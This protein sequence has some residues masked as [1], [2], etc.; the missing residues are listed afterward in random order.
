LYNTYSLGFDRLAA[1][2]LG[3]NFSPTIVDWP[4][5]ESAAQQIVSENTG[6]TDDS[7]YVLIGHSYGADDAVRMARLLN[8]YDIPVKLLF[9]LDATSPDPIPE[10]VSLCI[11]YYEPW[12]PGDLFPFLFS[13]NPVVAAPGNSRT[14]ITNLLFTR[15]ALGDGIGCANHFSID[16]NE[17]MHNLIMMELIQLVPAP[18]DA[19]RSTGPS[20]IG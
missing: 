11:H 2:L 9:L 4:K 1:E 13:G 7:E 15:E 5:W 20:S 10:N 6:P 14:Q 8:D 12:P 17:H 19:G 18:S 3:A 16:V